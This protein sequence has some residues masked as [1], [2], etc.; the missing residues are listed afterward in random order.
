MGSSPVTD[1]EWKPSPGDY[2]SIIDTGDEWEGVIGVLEE[3]IEATEDHKES[4]TVF[5]PTSSAEV[6][7]RRM[8]GVNDLTDYV[9]YE[10]R[11]NQNRVRIQPHNLERVDPADF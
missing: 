2:V 11:E 4:W 10:L 6:K 7:A 9:R 5:V 8:V 1:E 3:H